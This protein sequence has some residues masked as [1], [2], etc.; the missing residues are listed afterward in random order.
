MTGVVVEPL[1]SHIL[2]MLGPH[3]EAAASWQYDDEGFEASLL[4]SLK[5]KT[6]T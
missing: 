5:Q 4:S 1:A 3:Y 2:A 6:A